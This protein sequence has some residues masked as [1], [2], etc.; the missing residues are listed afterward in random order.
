MS[1]RSILRAA[2]A[3]LLLCLVASCGGGGGSGDGSG[4]NSPP[5]IGTRSMS[6]INSTETGLTY[7]YQV[8]LPSG[9]STGTARYPVVYAADGEYRFPV[10]ADQLD[11]RGRQVILVNVWHMGAARRW[12]DFTMPAR[13]HT[14][15]SSR[16]S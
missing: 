14:T 10:L 16:A 7:N 8:Y 3:A 4:S 15:G 6:T 12:I 13:R 9:Y 11:F 5:T 2:T 1:P